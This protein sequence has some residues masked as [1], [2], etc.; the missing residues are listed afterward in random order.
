MNKFAVNQGEVYATIRDLRKQMCNI[1]LVVNIQTKPHK[2][3]DKVLI[4]V[5]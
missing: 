3:A 1:E 4:I 5:A 2:D